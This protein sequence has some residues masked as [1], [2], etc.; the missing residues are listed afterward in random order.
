MKFNHQL[1][2]MQQKQSVP[3]LTY[4]TRK[5]TRKKIRKNS[6]Q[7]TK[8]AFSKPRYLKAKISPWALFHWG[9][10]DKEGLQRM[11]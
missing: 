8:K 9:Q 2:I 5:G 3:K 6:S 10:G 4:G 11:T 1:D 7:C